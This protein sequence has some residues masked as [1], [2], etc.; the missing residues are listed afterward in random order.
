MLIYI[1][2]LTGQQ[3]LP[4]SAQPLVDLEGS[5]VHRIHHRTGPPNDPAAL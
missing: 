3:H 2:I 4:R 1:Y 5:V